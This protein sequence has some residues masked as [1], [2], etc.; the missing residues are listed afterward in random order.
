MLGP[1][2][3]LTFALPLSRIISILFFTC[4]ASVA[5]ATHNRAGE[6]IYEHVSGFTYR[7]SII[8]FTKQS[9][10]AD[11]SSLHLRWGDEPPNTPEEEL[12]SLFRV[13]EI[14]NIGNDVKKNIYVGL[15]SYSGPG[16][17]IISVEDPNRNSGVL[18]INNGEP[19]T[20]QADKYSTSVNSIF[21]VRSTLVIRAGNNGHNN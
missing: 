14:F 8:T 1:V 11:R 19:G 21:S 18:N 9:A 20:P 4:L 12:D 15:H 7:I 5:F 10:Q 16:T 17:F 3:N 2:F 6:I 13:V